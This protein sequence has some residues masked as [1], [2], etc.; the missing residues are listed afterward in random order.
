MSPKSTFAV[1]A[2]MREEQFHHAW[3]EPH[4]GEAEAA[5]MDHEPCPQCFLPCLFLKLFYVVI[6]APCSICQLHIDGYTKVFFQTPTFPLSLLFN[7][8]HSLL[9]QLHNQIRE[10]FHAFEFAL[11]KDIASAFKIWSERLK[12]IDGTEGCTEGTKISWEPRRQS[13]SQGLRRWKHRPP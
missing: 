3:S 8:V 9:L 5:T 1:Q 6:P 7:L 4:V 12:I 2:W 10:S 11:R 13:F